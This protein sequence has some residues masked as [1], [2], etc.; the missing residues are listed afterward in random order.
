MKSVATSLCRILCRRSSVTTR[1]PPGGG[2]CWWISCRKEQQSTQKATARLSRNFGEPFKTKEGVG[3]PK[4]CVCIMTMRVHMCH[5]KRPPY[6]MDS[7]GISSTTL[8]TVR[9]LPPAT[10]TCSPLSKNTL[11]DGNSS[12]MR[13]CKKQ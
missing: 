2:F 7:A 12:Q 10:T 11:E 4:E 9:T 8:L 3:S 13:K 1:C 6:L 5:T